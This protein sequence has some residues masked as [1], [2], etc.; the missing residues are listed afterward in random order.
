MTRIAAVVDDDD[1]I[2]IGCGESGKNVGRPL[3]VRDAILSRHRETLE[4]S[5]NVAKRRSS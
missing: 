1:D 4:K 3:H 2:D 5:Q